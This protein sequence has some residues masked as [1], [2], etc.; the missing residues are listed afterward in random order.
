MSSPWIAVDAF[1]PGSTLYGRLQSELGPAG[2]LAWINLLCWAKRSGRDGTV[3]YLSAPDALDNLGLV[4][5][6]LGRP[7]EEWLEAFWRLLA[8]MK[9][10]SREHRR[11]TAGASRKVRVTNYKAWQK[12]RASAAG[13]SRKGSS[14]DTNDAHETR[15]DTTSTS[16]ATSTSPP[17]PRASQPPPTGP[18]NDGEID[19]QRRRT[20]TAPSRANGTNHRALGTNPRANDPV[21][22]WL[23]RCVPG[24]GRPAAAETVR[25]LRAAG[26]ADPVIEEACGYA[27]EHNGGSARYVETLALD[28]MA[29]RDP[30]WH[31]PTNGDEPHHIG[32]AF[33]DLQP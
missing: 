25:R 6:D 32:D 33:R 1:F 3:K 24:T 15:P 18:P 14:E 10:A 13:P 26:V 23:Q 22:A 17:S 8:K 21:I 30:T 29:Q 16:T 31:P 7:P 20:A 27:A 9:Q 11:S 5:A 19:Q 12:D 2:P 4:G 28:W